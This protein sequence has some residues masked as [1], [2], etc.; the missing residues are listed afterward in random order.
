MENGILIGEI[1][2]GIKTKKMKGKENKYESKRV[3]KMN[4]IPSTLASVRLHAYYV[5]ALVCLPYIYYNHKKNHKKKHKQIIN[6]INVRNHLL[7]ILRTIL[8]NM[9]SICARVRCVKRWNMICVKARVRRKTVENYHINLI[10]MIFTAANNYN[11]AKLL[12]NY[13]LL[14]I[15]RNI[16]SFTT[17]I[18][19]FL[20]RIR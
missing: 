5:F 9:R 17:L 6:K 15:N 11:Y 1:M 14:A 10:I 8:I 4:A 12:N 7:L 20:L 2:N 16:M 13:C 19:Q 18:V 3:F